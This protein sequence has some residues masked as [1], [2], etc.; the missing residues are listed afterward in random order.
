MYSE[1][2]GTYSILVSLKALDEN[3][4][5]KYQLYNFG[6]SRRIAISLLLEQSN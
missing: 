5:N 1:I 2:V 3:D 6:R 4:G